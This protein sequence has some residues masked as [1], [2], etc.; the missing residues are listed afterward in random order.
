MEMIDTDFQLEKKRNDA[1]ITK[2][3]MV[4]FL[5]VSPKSSLALRTGSRKRS[6]RNAA[7]VE[8]NLRCSVPSG[9]GLEMDDPCVELVV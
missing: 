9:K 3:G 7:Q 5:G 4:T 2:T 8:S 6:S 1:K